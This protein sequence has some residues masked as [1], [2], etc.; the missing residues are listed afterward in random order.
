MYKFICLMILTLQYLTFLHNQWTSP[1]NFP[2]RY[3]NSWKYE[4]KVVDK[5]LLFYSQ[6]FK[7]NK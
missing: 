3:S 2:Y 4:Y 5:V 1:G 7:N 6:R